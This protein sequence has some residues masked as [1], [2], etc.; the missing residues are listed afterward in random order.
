YILRDANIH[1]EKI[2]NENIELA[3]CVLDIGSYTKTVRAKIL[4]NH[5]ANA[6]LP[7]EYI[8]EFLKDKGYRWIIGHRNFNPRVIETYIDKQLWIQVPVS[9]FMNRFKEFFSNPHM[10]WEMA[11]ENLK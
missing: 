3:K 10:V 1:Y 2:R 11:F 8:S 5:I 6:D 9:E 4:Y 7:K